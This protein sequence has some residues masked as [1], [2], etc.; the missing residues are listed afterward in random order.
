M[1]AEFEQVFTGAMLRTIAGIVDVGELVLAHFGH[2]D[3]GAVAEVA[4]DRSDIYVHA[5]CSTDETPT[6]MIT[7]RLHTPGNMLFNLPAEGESCIVARGKDADGPGKPYALYGDCGAANQVPSWL[8]GNNAGISHKKTVHVESTN[9]DIKV[10]SSSGNVDL[11]GTVVNINGTNY[12]LLKTEDFMTDLAAFIGAVIADL[13]S[14]AAA[15]VSPYTAT[16]NTT[17]LFAKVVTGG[18]T[19]YKSTKAKNG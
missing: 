18:G 5:Q 7:A 4:D 16:V 15:P 14:A 6:G 3:G 8:D 13:A 12:S 2:V 19:A 17:Q 11:T 1:L 10:A 9:G